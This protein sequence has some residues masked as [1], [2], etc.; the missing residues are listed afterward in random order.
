[1]KFIYLQDSHIKGV[2]PINRIGNYYQD[3]MTKIKEVIAIAK[4][5]KVHYI[6]H[7]GDLFDSSHVSDRMVDDVIDTIEEKRIPFY[8]LPGNHDEIGHSWELSEGSSLAHIFRRSDFI[9]ILNWEADVDNLTWIQGFKYY[10]NIEEDIKKNGLMCQK[11]EAKFKIAIIHALI[12]E[13][14][15]MPTIMHIP[16][17]DVKTDFDVILVA[18]NHLQWGILEHKGVKFVN[19]GCLGRTGIDEVEIE[20]TI[21]YIDT[22]TREIELIPL[23][24]AKAGRE[25]FNLE[26]IEL[27]KAFEGEIDNFIKSLSNVKFQ[28]LDLRGLVEFLAKENNVE[29]EPKEELIKRIGDNENEF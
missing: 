6:I 15:L 11:K 24:S 13:K 25:V 28:S 23:K 16:I 22:E 8:I 4:K 3:V 29:K 14:P 20:P 26:K 12:T 19:I 1:M 7:G 18:H 9:R 2:N 27:A 5:M 21:A 10:H 17:K